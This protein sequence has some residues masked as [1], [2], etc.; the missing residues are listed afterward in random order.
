MDTLTSIMNIG[1]ALWAYK[2]QFL[3]EDLKLWMELLDPKITRQRK[4]EPFL[5]A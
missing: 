1:L 2:Q 3:Q 5:T 4:K